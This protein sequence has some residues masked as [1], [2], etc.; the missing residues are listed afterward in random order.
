MTFDR[1]LMLAEC[2]AALIAIYLAGWWYRDCPR[3]F[4]G[5]T[6]QDDDAPAEIT[7]LTEGWDDPPPDEWDDDWQREPWTDADADQL[8]AEW[9][10]DAPPAYGP[11]VPAAQLDIWDTWW[12]SLD[13]L[14]QECFKVTYWR[15][16]EERLWAELVAETKEMCAA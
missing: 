14:T 4:L 2:G 13:G 10:D 8:I 1:W 15:E 3:W 5:C 16:A 6:C 9:H 12:A 7:R 11:I